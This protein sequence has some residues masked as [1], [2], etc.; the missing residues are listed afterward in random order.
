MYE[1]IVDY[2]NAASQGITDVGLEHPSG[3]VRFEG[4]GLYENRVTPTRR[5]TLP[6]DR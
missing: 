2:S 4:L 3:S 5:K 1:W 6:P